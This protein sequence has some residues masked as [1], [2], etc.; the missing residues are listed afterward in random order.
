MVLEEMLLQLSDLYPYSVLY[1]SIGQ[2]CCMQ[3]S[4]KRK[5]R[6]EQCSDF[7]EIEVSRRSS[8]ADDSVLLLTQFHD[9]AKN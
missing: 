4:V 8:Y 6:Y 7:S 3:P 5:G 2:C 1:R 9:V